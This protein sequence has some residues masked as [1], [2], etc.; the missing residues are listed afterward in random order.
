MESEAFDNQFEQMVTHLG[1]KG[2]FV[3]V[4]N[5]FDSL[6]SSNKANAI[7]TLRRA[8]AAMAKVAGE[9]HLYTL[10]S[11]SYLSAA[12]ATIGEAV[13]AEDLDVQTLEKMRRCLGEDHAA[14]VSTALNLAAMYYNRAAYDE[15]E[16]LL[17]E[18]MRKL[19]NNKA[20]S[21]QPNAWRNH[22]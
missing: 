5:H 9:E 18:T 1:A 3:A 17:L 8:L 2:A 10:R 11:M 19:A 12:L 13:E 22:S 16:R 7:L 6:D 20:D 4:A 15:A 14:T 21:T